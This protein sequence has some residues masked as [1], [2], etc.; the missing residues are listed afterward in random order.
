MDINP[1]SKI[2]KY[3]VKN[4]KAENNIQPS[5]S[6]RD[7]KLIMELDKMS[8]MNNVNISKKDYELNLSK[9]ELEKR[10]HKDYLTTK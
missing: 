6:G 2:N 1:I 4:K 5:F 9:V 10:T 7:E 8:M 3:G